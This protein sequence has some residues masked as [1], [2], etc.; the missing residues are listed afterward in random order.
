MNEQAICFY[1]N[2][3]EEETGKLKKSRVESVETPWEYDG[4]S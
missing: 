3:H 2:N 1:F 4:I